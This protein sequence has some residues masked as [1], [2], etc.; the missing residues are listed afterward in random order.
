MHTRAHTHTLQAQTHL[1]VH[2]HHTYKHVEEDEG[3]K[4]DKE[5]GECPT[6]SKLPLVQLLLQVCPA[7]NLSGKAGYTEHQDPAG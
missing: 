4:Q 6:N 3:S 1:C 5:D 2:D 7:I